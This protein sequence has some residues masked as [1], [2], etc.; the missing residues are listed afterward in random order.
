[1]GRAQAGKIALDGSGWLAL[2]FPV[3]MFFGLG[4]TFLVRFATQN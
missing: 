1:M 2:Y 3:A 4:G